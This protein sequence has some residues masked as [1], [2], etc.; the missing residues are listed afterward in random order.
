MQKAIDQYQ[1]ETGKLVE[2]TSKAFA[3]KTTDS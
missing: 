3:P 2:M 1:A